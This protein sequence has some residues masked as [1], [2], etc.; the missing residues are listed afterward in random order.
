MIKTLFTKGPYFRVSQFINYCRCQ[1]EFN[2]AR[3]E[4]SG[5]LRL[6]HKLEDTA[7]SSWVKEVNKK[8]KMT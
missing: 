3:E 1:K 8:S 4:F 2:R 5:S 7:I 6:K